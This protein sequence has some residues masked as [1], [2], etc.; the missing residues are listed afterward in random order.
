MKQA[1]GMILTDR[2]VPATEGYDLGFV[3]EVVP[4]GQA[5]DGAKSWAADI[6]KCS[7]LSIRASIEVVREGMTPA[8]VADAINADCPAVARMRESEDFIEGPR[9]FAEKRAPSWSG[10]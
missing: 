8:S 3:T 10:R 6:E 2:R 4:E 1:M 7:P 5:P 9:A